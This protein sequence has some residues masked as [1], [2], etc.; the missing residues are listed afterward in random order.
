MKID[1]PKI[2]SLLEELDISTLID[3]EEER[4]ISRGIV[5]YWNVLEIPENKISFDQ[6]HFRDVVFEGVRFDQVEFID[7][8]F[9]RCDLSNVDFGDSV[10]HR[11]EFYQ[12]KLVGIQCTQSRFGHVAMKNCVANY[13]AFSF[14]KMKRVK[15]QQT[16]FNKSDFFEC[17]FDKVEFNECELDGS[18]F[19]ET[20][21]ENIDLSTCTYEQLTV[22]VEKLSGCTVSPEQA[23]GFAKSL[24]LLIKE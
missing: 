9:E 15:F 13:A 20:S 2:P 11:V 19:S 23:M 22:S 14:S 8:K 7:C 18:N 21:L 6:I 12:S 10:F 1:K 17:I 3:V 16:T 5:S 4:F 24:G